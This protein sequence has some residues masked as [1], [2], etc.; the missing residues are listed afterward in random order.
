MKRNKI[1]IKFSLL[2]LFILLTL[3]VKGEVKLPRLIGNGMVLQRDVPLNIWGWAN[4]SEKV[5]VKFVGK[6]YVTRADD[7]GNWQINLPAM[8]SGGPYDMEVNQV[9]IENI[10]IGDVWLSSGQS[11]MELPLRRVM[12]LYSAEIKQIDND[13]IRFFRSSSRKDLKNTQVDFPDGNWK[14][15]TQENVMEFSAVAYFFANKL[16][17]RYQVPIG[18]ISTAIGGSPIESWISTDNVKGYLEE[19][20]NKQAHND[21]VRAKI[22][23]ESPDKLKYNWIKEINSNDP[24][25]SVWSKEDVDVSNWPEISVPGYWGDKGVDLKQGSIWFCKEFEVAD[26][27]VNQDAVLRMGRIIDS[28]SAFINGTF[29]GTVSYQYPPRIYNVPKGILK[30]GKNKLM[31][32][33]IS[34]GWRG[35]FVE[36]KPYELRF[37]SQKIDLTGDWKYHVGAKVSPEHIPGNLQFMPGGL[38]NGLIHPIVGFKLKGVIWYQGESNTGRGKGYEELSKKLVT[39]W[40]KNLNQPELPFLYVQL[41]N[42]GLPSKVP[43]E[44]GW[45][46]VRDAQRRTLELPNTGMAVAFDLGE[47]NDIHP[48]NKKEIGRRL[49]L[50]AARVAYSNDTLVSSGPLYDSMQIESGYVI[51]T[52]KSVGAGL[53]ANSLLKGFQIAGED[54]HFKWANAV[55]ITKNTVKVWNYKISNPKMVRYGWEDNPVESNLKNKDGLPASPFTTVNK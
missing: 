54:G 45:A 28:D 33:I 10:L 55:V 7:K 43:V 34:N 52:F 36:E 16:Y 44:S 4:P 1:A 38:F 8:V 15:A 35:G 27:L 32:R 30:P 21:S 40:R 20:N 11:N 24:G 39:D 53:Y 50:E 51:L 12:D 14:A 46:E 5:K 37:A 3:H 22:Q 6:S 2:Y 47:W 29:V 31:V 9:R 48:L 25:V 18:I 23:Q 42:L 49:A 26:S 41:A 13:Q 19:W 17:R